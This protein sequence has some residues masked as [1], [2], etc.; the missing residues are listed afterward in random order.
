MSVQILYQADILLDGIAASTEFSK[1]KFS[2]NQPVKDRTAFQDVARNFIP[3]IY[4]ASANGEFYYQT[5]NT[6]N[7]TANKLEGITVGPAAGA[8][9]P[10]I[11]SIAADQ[12]VG[13]LVNIWRGVSAK[14]EESAQ[15]GEIIKVMMDT[16]PADRTV[17][18]TRLIRALNGVTGTSG[19]GAAQNLGA[20]SAAQS[21]YSALHVVATTGGAAGT[22]FSVI[23]S[24]TSGLTA[25]TTR[26][27]FITGTSA[28]AGEWGPVAAGAITDIWWAFKWV[29]YTGT[30]CTVSCSAG[31]Q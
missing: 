9:V 31:I 8:F 25:P 15:H 2:L 30:G 22:V 27:T 1:I 24:A 11:L 13:N 3:G 19:L 28:V 6:G 17:Q 4:S 10:M 14:A 26:V 12:V 5:G 18:A 21:L 16:Q 29:S 23:S 20:L 7:L